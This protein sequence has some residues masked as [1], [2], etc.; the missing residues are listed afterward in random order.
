MNPEVITDMTQYVASVVG[1]GAGYFYTWTADVDGV[2]EITMLSDDWTFIVNNLT[3]YTYGDIHSSAGDASSVT[4]PVKVGDELQINIGTA[5]REN[6]NV[7]MAFDSYDPDYG[8]KDNPLWLYDQVNI[9]SVRPNAPVYAKVLHSDVTM[10]VT[11]DVSVTLGGVG[12][13]A[14]DGKVTVTGVKASRFMPLEL[15]ITNSGDKKTE[16]TVEFVSPVGTLANPE[17]I[18]EMGIYTAPVVADSQGYFYTWTAPA[19]GQFTLSMLGDDWIYVIYGEINSSAAKDPASKSVTVS[20]GDQIEINVGTASNKSL[21]VQLEFQFQSVAKSAE[22]IAVF[23][24]SYIP[25]DFLVTPEEIQ[26]MGVLDL[27]NEYGLWASVAGIYHLDDKFGPLV[28]VD[29]TDDTFVNLAELV[30]SQ[31]LLIPVENKDG[32]VSYL[33]CNELLEQYIACGWVVE[34]SAEV[35]HTYYPLTEDLEYVLKALGQ[36]LGWFDSASEGY[37][38]GQDAEEE[39]T[40]ET[41]AY[42]ED[43]LWMF[44]CSYIAFVMDEVKDTTTAMEAM[45]MSM[46]MEEI[47]EA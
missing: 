46:A 5:S 16:V 32:T 26:E 8:T 22:K 21:D 9:I 1:D 39:L 31:N 23:E 12:Y 6:K 2:F 30:E 27:T 25:K 20:A 44:P 7:V 33:R 14:V 35:V 41:A 11:G 43:S 28:L 3:S 4:V 40:E 42:A 47:P 34:V 13:P 38:F 37:L 18:G 17:E 36:E 29:F 10:I 15:L 19:D 45:Q 24:G